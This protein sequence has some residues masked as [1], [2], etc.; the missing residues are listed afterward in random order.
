[1]KAV[2][3]HI[4]SIKGSSASIGANKMFVL[5]RYLNDNCH[6]NESGSVTELFPCLVNIFT[7]T[8]N[9]LQNTIRQL[10]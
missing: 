3:N 2:Y 1:M 7:E 6:E 4:H 9:N 8:S 5:S 10:V